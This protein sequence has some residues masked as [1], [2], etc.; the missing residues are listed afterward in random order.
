VFLCL[1]SYR[2]NYFILILLILGKEKKPRYYYI[3]IVI[4]EEFLCLELIFI[5]GSGVACILRPLAILA[6][7]LSALSIAFLNDRYAT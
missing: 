7:A 6:T 1:N 2:T 4:Y 5:L 3:L